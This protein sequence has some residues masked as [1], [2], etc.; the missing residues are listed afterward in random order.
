MDRL[1]ILFVGLGSI[2]KRH[3]GNLREICREQGRE[4]QIDAL[5]SGVD[6]N[7]AYEIKGDI[8]NVYYQEEEISSDY[9]IVFITNPTE[10]HLD[11][12]KKVHF[13]SR[14][15]FIEKPVCSESQ[16]DDMLWGPWRKG[17]IYYVACPLRYTA[18]IQYLK[19]NINFGEVFSVRCISS[20]YLPEWRSHVDYRNT[21]SAHRDLGG[22]VSIDLIHEWD[23][24]YYL[25]GKP[26]KVY[27]IIEKVSNLEIDS[28]DIAVYI[29][30]YRGLLVEL[31]LDYFGRNPIRQMEIFMKEDTLLC[32]LIESSIVFMKS[33]K[34]IGFGQ[35][36]N[37]F[38]RKELLHFLDIIEGKAENENDIR[39]A[40]STLKLAKGIT[41]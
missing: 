22:G 8:A 23:Y 32:D 25:L 7:I 40:C 16:I 38:Q 6:K 37:D 3:I 27:G 5:R 26:Q 20:S 31:H 9:D 28:D 29:A 14:H 39:C 17:S 11:A 18:V 10:F 21:Y 36:R 24:L 30:R 34:K 41:E 19:E 15:F 4:Y 35:E 33:G 1:K 12:L 13:K 2:A